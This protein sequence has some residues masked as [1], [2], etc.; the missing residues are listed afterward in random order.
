MDGVVGV[1]NK[2]EEGKYI[3]EIYIYGV[4]AE[5]ICTRYIHILYISRTYIYIYIINKETKKL[6]QN[7]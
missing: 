1:C 5:Y 7:N 2:N 3:F 6:K 4:T